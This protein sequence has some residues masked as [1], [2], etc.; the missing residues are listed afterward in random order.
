MYKIFIKTEPTVATVTGHYLHLI[1]DALASLGHTVRYGDNWALDDCNLAV[2]ATAVG[3]AHLARQG[4][5][6]ILW[7]QGIW[8]EESFLRHGSRLRFALTGFLEREAL[9][10]ARFCFFVSEAMRAHFEEKYR[11]SFEGR[12]YIMPC[13][14]ERFHPEVFTT[15]GK[16]ERLTFCYLGSTAVWQCF[17]ETVALFAQIQAVRQDARL[18]L[19]VPDRAEAERVLKKYGV[20]G[21]IDYVDMADLPQRLKDVHYGFLLRSDTTVNRVATPTK[22]ATYLCSGVMPIYS[23]CMTSV[24]QIMDATPYGF[25][26][27]DGDATALTR[28]MITHADPQEVQKSF[29]S[30]YERY[31]DPHTHARRIAA[32]FQAGLE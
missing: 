28:A 6:Y 25:S 23:G 1:G 15:P 17:E 27:H 12:C 10:K 14:N 2:T 24:A 30:I 16:Y 22:L 32:L 8:P 19:L 5:P 21:E 26:C 18:L 29:A 13:C 31:Y 3:A 20:D 4:I 11:L 7:C 9:R